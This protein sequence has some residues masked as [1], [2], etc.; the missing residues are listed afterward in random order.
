MIDDFER[1]YRA[2][3]ARDA[4]FDGV[5]VTAVTSTGIY[6]RPSCPALTPKPSN[7]RFFRTAAAAQSEGFRACKRCRPDAAPGSPEWNARGDLV[8]RAMRLIADG[9][10]DRDGVEGLAA[11]LHYSPRHLHRQL[12]A[13]LGA[14]PQAIARAHRAQTARILIET[15][16]LP[17]SEVA[18]AA[19]FSSVRQFNETIM[20]VFAATPSA[21][22]ARSKSARGA[23]GG[24]IVLRLALRRP[25]DSE[26]TFGFLGA[27]AVP[28]VESGGS[29]S[30]R[31]SLRL[32]HSV[33]IVSLT[34]EEGYVSCS[35][36]L[37]DAR[38]LVA[39]VERCRRILDLDADPIAIDDVL[40][41]DDIL[42]PLVRARPGL[43]IPGAADGFEQAV[44]AVIGQQISI[45]AAT[46]ITARLVQSFGKP[47]TRPAGD[48]THLFPEAETIAESDLKR[49]GIQSKKQGALRALATAV[50]G[51]SIALDPGADRAETTARLLE[52]PGI[53]PWTASYVAMRALGDPDAFMPSDLGVTH[54]LQRLGVARDPKDVAR[55]WRPWRAYA[56]QHL[57]AIAGKK[58]V[59]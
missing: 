55:R 2:V 41:A 42:A 1:C 29:G 37:D 5:F 46:S 56:Q 12:V 32:P 18:F 26:W 19:G 3:A 30:Y 52:V 53:G 39:A 17:L 9:A 24:D 28:G 38:D 16:S 59:A 50:A 36:G 22:R 48:V 44:R 20:K 33:A 40:G 6:C 25:F 54:G 13:E 8:G 49:I 57:W 34:P 27:R 15:T 45:S 23:A 7:V 4:R 11:R 47:L 21:L 31:R 58:E 51:G 14:G 35:L 43:R 10:V